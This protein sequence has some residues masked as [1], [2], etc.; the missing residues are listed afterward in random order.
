MWR[1]ILRRNCIHREFT[2]VIDLSPFPC[3]SIRPGKRQWPK[4]QTPLRLS[5]EMGMRKARC[6]AGSGE[7]VLFRPTNDV[8]YFRG[9]SV[10]LLMLVHTVVRA[11]YSLFFP[12]KQYVSQSFRWTQVTVLA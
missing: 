1:S 7:S 9:L 4:L 2:H 11:C 5:A 8:V 3:Q 10:P 6:L 12:S